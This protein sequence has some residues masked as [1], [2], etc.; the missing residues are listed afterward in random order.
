[1]VT[2]VLRCFAEKS[3]GQWTAVCLDFSLAAQA[4]TAEEAIKSLNSQIESYI[5]DAF[6]GDDLAH[7]EALLSR[8][9][10]V[11]LWAR[12]YYLKAR[13]VFQRLV[14]A[15]P[16]KEKVFNPTVGDLAHC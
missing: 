14:H 10:P 11:S 16:P 6:E 2:K 8:R 4:D 12:Y 3:E 7:R 5:H 15:R 1:M 9:A 13:L